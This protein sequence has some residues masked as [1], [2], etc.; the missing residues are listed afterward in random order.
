VEPHW[1]RERDHDE[2]DDERGEGQGRHDPGNDR[3]IGD[4]PAERERGGDG[5]R[6]RQRGRLIPRGHAVRE[7]ATRPDERFDPSASEPARPSRSPARR[8][9][10]PRCHA[11][12]WEGWNNRVPVRGRRRDGADRGLTRSLVSHPFSRLIS[13]A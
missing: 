10:D 2:E 9:L 6:E 12:T 7:E 1:G 3:R 11:R 13:G 4:H 5:D 8:V